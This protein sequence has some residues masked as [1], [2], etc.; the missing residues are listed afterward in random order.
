MRI[1]FDITTPKTCLFFWKLGSLLKKQGHEIFYVGRTYYESNRMQEILNME[2]KLIGYHGGATLQG[3]LK[4]GIERCD[5]LMNYFNMLEPDVFISLS[6]VDGSRVAFGLNIPIICFNDIPEAQH[7][8]RLTVPLSDKVFIPFVVPPPK[9]KELGAKNIIV[10]NSLDPVLWLQDW[11]INKEIIEEQGLDKEEPIIVFRE[12]ETK[13]SYLNMKE[14]FVV[15]VVQKLMHKHKNWQ[16]IGIP[17]YSTSFLKHALPN[18][19]ILPDM[20]DTISLLAKSGL[21]LGGGGTM[22]IE[23]AYFGT[24]TINLRPLTCYY[25]N[26]LIE[27]GLSFKTELNL[28]SVIALSEDIINKRVDVPA[29][30]V[31]KK[32][33]F[34]KEQILNEIVKMGG[35][36]G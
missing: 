5:E 1:L 34:P 33:K 9:I 8:A 12:E 29:H 19:V 6:S 14:S 17:R 35:N 26:Y 23:S 21:F 31:F 7:S 36:H 4:S 15:K 32:L 25:E 13:A 20:G 11:E 16:F 22:N 28:N 18:A 3:K 30:K 10:Y 24:P 2:V 27:N